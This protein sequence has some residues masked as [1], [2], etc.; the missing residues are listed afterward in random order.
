MIIQSEKKSESLQINVQ[1]SME[2]NVYPTGLYSMTG[3][4]GEH[5]VTNNSV[6]FEFPEKFLKALREFEGTRKGSIFLKGS[7]G[8]HISIEPDGG[9]GAAWLDFAI[10]KYSIVGSRQTGSGK[11]AKLSLTGGFSIPGDYLGR[12]VQ[13]FADLFTK[14]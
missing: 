5:T 14:R 3:A 8:C 6:I 11:T 4:I 13:D 7:E 2:P 12:L 1:S 10:S 9:S